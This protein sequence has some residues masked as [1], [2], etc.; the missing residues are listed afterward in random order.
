LKVK[1][2]EEILRVIGEEDIVS[3]YIGDNYYEAEK[4]SDDEL[5]FSLDDTSVDATKEVAD[6]VKKEK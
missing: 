2:V 4:L 1:E 3:L 5:I 6:V